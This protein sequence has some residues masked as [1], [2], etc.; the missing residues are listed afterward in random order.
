MPMMRVLCHSP[1]ARES[2]VVV[3]AA[4]VSLHAHW[5]HQLAY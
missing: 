3:E 2:M 5:G 1:V 4:V